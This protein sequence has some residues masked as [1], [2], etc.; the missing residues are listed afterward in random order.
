MYIGSNRCPL[1]AGP[2]RLCVFLIPSLQFLGD[3]LDAVCR[4]ITV[5]GA[6]LNMKRDAGVCPSVDVYLPA[7]LYG[8]F[9]PNGKLE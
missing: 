5:I 3:R 9:L 8:R 7:K 1:L 6:R 4:F 2:S